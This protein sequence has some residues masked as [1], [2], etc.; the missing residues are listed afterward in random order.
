LTHHQL[1]VAHRGQRGRIAD[2]FDHNVH[3]AAAMGRSA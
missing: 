3:L 1:A 2:R